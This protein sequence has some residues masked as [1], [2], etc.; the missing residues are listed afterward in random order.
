MD[1]AELEQL[2]PVEGAPV[3]AADKKRRNLEENMRREAEERQKKKREL[4][5]MEREYEKL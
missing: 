2:S 1:E 4:L 5:R 3:L